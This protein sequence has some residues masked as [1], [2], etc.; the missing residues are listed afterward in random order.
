M[1]CDNFVARKAGVR[2][3]VFPMEV[4]SFLVVIRGL[5]KKEYGDRQFLWSFCLLAECPV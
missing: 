2:L 3:T 4:E 5:G 1:G